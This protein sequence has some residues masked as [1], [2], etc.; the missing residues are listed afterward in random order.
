MHAILSAHRRWLGH[1]LAD[2]LRLAAPLVLGQLSAIGM[3]LIDTLLAGHLNAPTLGAVALGS[4][5][6]TLAIIC[7]IGVMMCLQ[8]SVAQLHG[9]GRDA[10]IAPLFRQAL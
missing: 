7:I 3:N 9:A 2:T 6:W 5:V 1:E 10:H 4:N 8:P